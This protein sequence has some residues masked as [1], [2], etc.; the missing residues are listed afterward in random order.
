MLDTNDLLSIIKKAATEA[1]E[2]GQPSNFCFGK[3]TSANPLEISVEQKM[4]LSSAQLV[5]TRN[6]TDYKI[7]MTVNHT[8]DIAD[9][10]HSH[11][12]N[13]NTDTFSGNTEKGGEDE[14]H[15]HAYAHQHS[16]SGNIESNS[17]NLSHN[18]NYSGRKTFLVHNG[19]SIGENV[20]LFKQKGGQKYLVLDRVV[21]A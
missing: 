4:V 20:V 13:G 19:L 15:V 18:H 14:P 5:L 11:S 9:L 10:Q 3:V 6:V 2:A 1:V 12:I 16:L 17:A 8:T 21:D 7:E